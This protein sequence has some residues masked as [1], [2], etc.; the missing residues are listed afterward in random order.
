DPELIDLM[1]QASSHSSPQVRFWGAM[2][3]G[4]VHH[5]RGV[6]STIKLLGDPVKMVR[7]AAEWAMKQTLLDDVEFDAVFAAYEKGDDLTRE[8]FGK[9][10]G[11][12]ADAV[13]TRPRFDMPRLTRLL[14]RALNDDPSPSVRAWASKAAWQWWV[15]NPPARDAIEQAWTRK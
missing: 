7:D 4:G 5:E 1:I 9:A 11:M 13:M 3:L 6:P 8:R 14:D 10:V 12:R 2:A 15:W